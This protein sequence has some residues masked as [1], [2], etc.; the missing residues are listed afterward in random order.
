MRRRRS[1]PAGS[2]FVVRWFPA[3]GVWRPLVG[4]TFMTPRSFTSASAAERAGRKAKAEYG[5]VIGVMGPSDD[6]ERDCFAL[7]APDESPK[8]N[9]L[10]DVT[11][12]EAGNDR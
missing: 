3:L 6:C 5:G 11:A 9:A 12:A 7:S 2:F 8:A 4:F 1:A 10:G